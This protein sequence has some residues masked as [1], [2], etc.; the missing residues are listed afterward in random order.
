MAVKISVI[1]A[2][3]AGAGTAAATLL[4]APSAVAA[5]NPCAASQIARTVGSVGTNTGIYLEAHPETNEVLTMLAAQPAGPNSIA[6]LKLYFERDPQAA[7]D[8][9]G[10][11]A[12]ADVADRQ[13]QAADLAATGSRSD[14]G[15]PAG[16]CTKRS[17][18]RFAGC[19][20]RRHRWRAGC[21]STACRHRKRPA[22]RSV[23]PGSSRR[24]HAGVGTTQETGPGI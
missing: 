2:V 13:V 19:G 1:T 8:L 4:A 10:H 23:R 6:A 22:L 16:R 7:E 21:G 24:E 9:G 3:L 12:T 11:S 17:T 14:A 18:C 15:G 20:Q 5:P